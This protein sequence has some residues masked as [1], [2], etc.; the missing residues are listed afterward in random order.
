M[1]RLFGKMLS[2]EEMFIGHGIQFPFYFVIGWWV[3]PLALVS[4]MLWAYG[5]AEGTSKAWRRIGVPAATAGFVV[6]FNPTMVWM[7]A[8][9]P[10]GWGALT[11]GYGMPST[12]PPDEG[13]TL[14]RLML[15]VLKNYKIAEFATRLTTYLLFWAAFAAVWAV[16]ARLS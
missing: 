13:S 2:L 16:I 5:G 12:Q 6:A 14:G 9:I 11:V 3:L 15:K 8:F 7:L 10:A 4:S 1:I